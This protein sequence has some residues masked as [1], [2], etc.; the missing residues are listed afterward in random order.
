MDV[1]ANSAIIVFRNISIL[2]GRYRS[3]PGLLLAG[4]NRL[5]KSLSSSTRRLLNSP[6]RM[7]IKIQI[8]EGSRAASLKRVRYADASLR[9]PRLSPVRKLMNT[10]SFKFAIPIRSRHV[11]LAVPGDGKF[12]ITNQAGSPSAM[13][14]SLG[15]W[16]A[17][18]LLLSIYPPGVRRSPDTCVKPWPRSQ[19]QQINPKH[20][21]PQEIRPRL[22]CRWSRKSSL[23]GKRLCGL[24]RGGERLKPFDD[25]TR[26]GRP[27]Q[28]IR[29]EGPKSYKS[30]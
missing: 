1:T 14:F 5:G 23:L 9:S 30:V 24:D 21:H 16:R 26:S 4:G 17:N 2:R 27:Y 20:L 25:S 13:Q 11:L 28:W 18:G 10:A 8:S 15:A 6:R 7:L 12:R 3:Q 19:R 22:R 29:S